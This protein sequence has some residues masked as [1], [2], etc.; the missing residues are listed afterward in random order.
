MLELCLRTHT[1]GS[2]VFFWIHKNH[3]GK[4]RK[5]FIRQTSRPRV[6]S[7]VYQITKQKKQNIYQHIAPFF[8]CVYAYV[9]WSKTNFFWFRLPHAFSSNL[10]MCFR[11]HINVHSGH[12]TPNF[13]PEKGRKQNAITY[14]NYRRYLSILCREHI[15]ASRCWGR[16]CA[17]TLAPQS[18]QKIS[19]ICGKSN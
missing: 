19:Q 15:R 11:D 17:H 9:Q 3:R 6:Q 1:M 13:I 14:S 16:L 7:S 2:I 12:G 4:K 5:F 18:G 10:L 8:V